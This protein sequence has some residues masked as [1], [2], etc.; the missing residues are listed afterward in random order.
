MNANILK[1]SRLFIL[2]FL[3]NAPLSFAYNITVNPGY[4]KGEVIVRGYGFRNVKTNVN[5]YVDGTFKSNVKLERG[6]FKQTLRVS[7]RS[8]NLEVKVLEYYSRGKRGHLSRTFRIPHRA[9]VFLKGK[10]HGDKIVNGRMNING[11]GFNSNKTH[12]VNFYR[13]GKF[14]T[15]KS[16]RHGSFHVSLRSI[17]NHDSIKVRVLD[18]YGRGQHLTRYLT[19]KKKYTKKRTTVKAYSYKIPRYTPTINVSEILESGSV[20]VHGFDFERRHNVNIFL[21]GRYVRN[22]TVS[23]GNFDLNLRGLNYGDNVTVKVLDYYGPGFH[24]EQTFYPARDSQAVWNAVA[25]AT[26]V[27][28]GA[29]ALGALFHAVS[30]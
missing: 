4:N 20:R 18:Y 10:V 17:K 1:I 26:A 29:V 21:N 7:K 12:Q 27:A 19:A 14:L 30:H 22:M 15:S 11:S 25:G 24:L 28:A 13:N 16:M 5:F 23:N 2:G 3:L 9:K 8:R 6:S